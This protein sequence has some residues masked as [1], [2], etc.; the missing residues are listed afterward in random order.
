MLHGVGTLQVVVGWGVRLNVNRLV[1]RVARAVVVFFLA[2]SLAFGRIGA[3]PSNVAARYDFIRYDLNEIEF[4]GDHKKSQFKKFFAAI[5]SIA[6]GRRRQVKML[7]IGG[8]HIQADVWSGQLR[9]RLYEWFPKSGGA[10]GFIFPQKLRRSN[11]S[12]TFR[13]NYTGEWIGAKCTAAKSRTPLGLAGVSAT[14]TDSLATLE[15]ILVDDI[16][17]AH[18]QSRFTFTRAKIFHNSDRRHHLILLADSTLRA[19]QTS[20]PDSGYTEFRFEKPM[21]QLAVQFLKIDSIAG[22]FTLYGIDLQNDESGFVYHAVGVN[23]AKVSSYLGCDLLP[24]HVRALAPDLITLSVGLNDAANTGFNA[25]KF[26]REYDEFIKTLRRA[27]P[28]AAIL[29]TTVTDNYKRRRVV[30]RNTVAVREVFFSLAKKHHAAVWDLFSIMGGLES[31][32]RWKAA[33]LAKRDR[34]HFTPVGYKLIGDL[35]FDALMKAYHDKRYAA[36]D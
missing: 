3:Q 30:N 17:H 18:A 24:D 13:V 21:T 8:S 28:D 1:L 19:V 2:Q 23:G 12:P 4:F 34:M 5:D 26:E 33:G 36:T 32:L 16:A 11:G 7:H 25:Q 9:T 27:A 35:E 6:A 22:V 10:R 20:P 15:I 29:F 31:I 14:T